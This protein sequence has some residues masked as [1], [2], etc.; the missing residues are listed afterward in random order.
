MLLCL[1]VDLVVCVC[2]L[3]IRVDVCRCF[4]VLV[5]MLRLLKRCG[6]DE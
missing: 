2:G 6:D 4:F 3:C 5:G 1:L